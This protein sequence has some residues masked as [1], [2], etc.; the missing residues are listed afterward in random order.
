MA[1]TTED[2]EARLRRAGYGSIPDADRARRLAKLAKL[3]YWL[4]DRFR[5]PGTGIRIGLDGMVGFIPGV[6]DTA[7]LALSGWIV[8]EAWRLGMPRHK[9]AAMAGTVGVDYVIGLVPLVG[10]I[11]D[12]GYKANRRNIARILKHFEVPVDPD[13]P[14]PV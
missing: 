9:I 13:R 10:D 2:W 7:T 5:I 14:Y 3:A 4:D 1:T 12:V 8:L 11:F 6:G